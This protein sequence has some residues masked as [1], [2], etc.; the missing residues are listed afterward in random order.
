[1]KPNIL[2]LTVLLSINLVAQNSVPQN[3]ALIPKG[4]FNMGKNTPNPTDWQP[5]QKFIHQAHYLKFNKI[6]SIS[7]LP[8]H[9]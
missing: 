4:E 2:I 6:K 1:M 7:T 5:W 8:V 9:L 3:M